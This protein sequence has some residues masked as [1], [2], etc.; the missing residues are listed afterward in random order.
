[1]DVTQPRWTIPPAGAWVRARSLPRMTRRGSVLPESPEWVGAWHLSTADVRYYPH[2]DLPRCDR[3]LLTTRCGQQ[4]QLELVDW[5]GQRVADVV[6]QD[7]QPIADACGRC[8]RY[9]ATP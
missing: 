5:A 8:V 3:M 9:G 1:M 4:L 7:E 6:T 2:P